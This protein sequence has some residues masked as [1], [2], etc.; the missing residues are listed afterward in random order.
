MVVMK[1]CIV[2][3]LICL[4]VGAAFLPNISRAQDNSNSVVV[5]MPAP[6]DL[7][8]VTVSRFDENKRDLLENLF[9][10]LTRFNASTGQIEPYLA[11]KWV[12]SP[13][14]LTWTFTLRDDIQWIEMRDGEP[15]TVRPVVAG[16]VVFAVQRACDPNRPSPITDNM[17]I[18]LGCHEIANALNTWE[19]TQELL[20]ERLGVKALDD[21]TVE[22]KLAFAGSYFLTLTA[23]PEFRPLPPERVIG[24]SLWPIATDMMTNGAW[25]VESWD[26][27]QMTLQANPLWPL[28]RTGN[29]EMVN[30]R[31]DI[32]P[33]VLP[34]QFTNGEVAIA[35]VGALTANT[36]GGV[37]SAA[38]KT[39]EGKTLS[40][41]GFSFEYPD[42]NNPLVRRALSLAI[43]RD[44]IAQN[45]AAGD[46]QFQSMT[47]FTPRTVIAAPSAPG[48]GFDPITAQNLLAESGHAGCVFSERLR[49]AV[50]ND[51]I[52]TL[53]AQLT[54]QQ[55]QL[56]L[57]CAE[58]AFEL[59]VVPRQEIVN[60]A[61]ANIDFSEEQLRYHLWL[62]TWTGDYPDADAWTPYALH[63]EYGYF[64]VGRGCDNTD[65]LLNQAATNSDIRVRLDTYTRAET[66]FFGPS[67]SFP[68]IPLVITSQLRVQQAWLSGV[69]SY[70]PFQFDRWIVNQS[71]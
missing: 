46:V 34:S 12:V 50:E 26:A 35:R 55:W 7:E 14:G 28:E 40:L 48:A 4:I 16:D 67:G 43:D 52:A 41:L 22:F 32:G 9:V 39:S 24:S 27:A 68:V 70:G 45:L 18:I 49:L 2:L 10:G 65:L 69:A 17:V 21:Q 19:I 13:D 42:L 71:E 6:A 58:G 1:R 20:D 60:N 63:C 8:L 3:F 31:F 36:I 37:D 66:E 56:N 5:A 29:L 54:I 38:V 47:R 51:P 44:F 64:R 57:G 59:V 53:I 25:V 11:T 33:D 62:T 61:H 15:T 30:I 23:L